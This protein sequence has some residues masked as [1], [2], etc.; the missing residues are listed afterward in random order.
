MHTSNIEKIKEEAKELR[1]MGGDL[2]FS[3]LRDY[4]TTEDQKYISKKDMTKIP[5][6]KFKYQTWYSKSYKLI[7]QIIPD[8]AQDFAN[9][10][11]YPRTRKNISFQNYTIKDALQ[12][13]IIN[14]GTVTPK[15]ALPELFQQI[16]IFDAAYST[17]GS[18]INDIISNLQSNVFDSEIE[19]A[20]NLKKAGHLRASGTICGVLIEKHLLL[21]CQSHN[22]KI[23][24][25]NPS[26][27]D[28]NEKLKSEKILEHTQW[29]HIQLMADIRNIC[30]HAKGKEPT[31]DQIDDIISGTNK[32][33]KSIF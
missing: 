29:R 14:G 2:I 4:G 23:N 11:E 18:A 33:I 28:L 8:R 22:I 26:I 30:S 13:L 27:S 15:D 24:K 19:S 1:K 21:V 6:F 10:Y 9:F 31:N 17:L 7:K 20:Q 12:G 32:I 16:A 25:K 5:L 3:F